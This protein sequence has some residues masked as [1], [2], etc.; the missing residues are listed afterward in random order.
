MLKQPS[1]MELIKL[2]HSLKGELQ[3]DEKDITY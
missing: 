3:Y 1:D 2:R